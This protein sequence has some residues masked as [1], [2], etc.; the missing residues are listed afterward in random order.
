M[1]DQPIHP[2]RKSAVPTSAE[3][4][5]K[6]AFSYLEEVERSFFDKTHRLRFDDTPDLFATLDRAAE[7]VAS[8]P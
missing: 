7:Y 8:A 4:D 5:L 1:A 6:A 2:S 3:Q